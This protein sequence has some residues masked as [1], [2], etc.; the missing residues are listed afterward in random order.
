MTRKPVA[1]LT[2]H[3]VAGLVICK[4]A[5]LNTRIT[6]QFSRQFS[7]PAVEELPA[8]AGRPSRLADPITADEVKG[9]IDK[10]NS[11]RASRHDDLPAEL[12]KYTAG[13]LAHTSFTIN[14]DSDAEVT[15][16]TLSSDTVGYVPKHSVSASVDFL[17][18]DLSRTF[19]TTHR[20][21]LLYILHTFLGESELRI[22]RFLLAAISLESCLST[23]DCHEFTTTIGKPQGDSLS[24]VLLTDYLGRMENDT[25]A[26][27]ASW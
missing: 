9:A 27:I 26:R 23:G 1:K 6:E 20:D 5:E 3:D 19:D 10:L 24:P 22:N 4:E 25:Q 18:I 17:G 8:F 7:D 14:R 2:I 11:S 12:L 15:R 13:S 16:P 21:K